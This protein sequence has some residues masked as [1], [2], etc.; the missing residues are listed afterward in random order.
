[1]IGWPR[2]FLNSAT[3]FRDKKPPSDGLVF[4]ITMSGLF[5]ICL[6]TCSGVKVQQSS[7]KIRYKAV[8][9][10]YPTWHSRF[11]PW[12]VLLILTKDDPN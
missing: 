1:M 7:V 6:W 12:G 9:A 2:S 11:V 8:T 5:L 10:Q 4:S 3:Y